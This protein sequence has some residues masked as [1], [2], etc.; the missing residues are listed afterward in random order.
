M[1]ETIEDQIFELAD[2]VANPTGYADDPGE[3]D[4]R[5]AKRDRL[6]AAIRTVIDTDELFDQAAAAIDG[7]AYRIQVRDDVGYA[8]DLDAALLAAAT[9]TEDQQADA[10]DV[11]ATITVTV[12]GSPSPFATSL[13]RRGCRSLAE[14]ERQE[15][16]ALAGDAFRPGG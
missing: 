6:A 4:R 11:R 13:A 12:H 3:A 15:L 7:A 9:M 10:D 16:R 1:S 5:A 2:H 14:F 8:S